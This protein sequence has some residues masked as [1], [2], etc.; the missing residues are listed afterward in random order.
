MNPK[1]YKEAL[2]AY[3]ALKAAEAKKA[4][5]LQHWGIKGMKWGER[6]YQYKDGSLTPEGRERYGVGDP[7]EKARLKMAADKQK[8]KLEIKR[9]KAEAKLQ[10]KMDRAAAKNDAIRIKAEQH[11][12]VKE[13]EEE[14]KQKQITAKEAK[15]EAKTASKDSRFS[16]KK[17]LA[18]A[19][20]LAGAAVIIKRMS[21]R[22]VNSPEIKQL[23]AQGENSVKEL[24]MY[25][26]SYESAQKLLS[27]YKN[28]AQSNARVA[29]GLR[30]DLNL[31]KDSYNASQNLLNNYKSGYDSMQRVFS[32]LKGAMDSGKVVFGVRHSAIKVNRIPKE[33]EDHV[34]T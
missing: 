11:G 29:M 8:A 22:P 10:M 23:A 16:T 15:Y 4:E 5:D 2:E 28:A 17:L 7:R 12:Q 26:D 31:Y 20:I 24:E 32:N 1:D 18:G 14:T 3:S 6:K 13:A 34:T 21:N 33:V 27:T 19:A 30:K 25:K 9:N